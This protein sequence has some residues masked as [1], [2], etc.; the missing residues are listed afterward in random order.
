MKHVYQNP[1]AQ[2][3]YVNPSDVISLS[4]DS[5]ISDYEAWAGVNDQGVDVSMWG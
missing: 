2:I 4:T 5:D 1:L 3:L